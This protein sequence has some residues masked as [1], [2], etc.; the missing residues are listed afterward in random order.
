M[1][2]WDSHMYVQLMVEVDVG[3][4][5]GGKKGTFLPGYD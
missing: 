1:V 5:D 4:P 2:G 3:G